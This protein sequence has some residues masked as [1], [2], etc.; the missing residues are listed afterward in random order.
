MATETLDFGPA[1]PLV[2]TTPSALVDGVVF[3][4]EL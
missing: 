2:R 4:E 3:G 1:D